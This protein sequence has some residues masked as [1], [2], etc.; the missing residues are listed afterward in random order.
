MP[1]KDREVSLTY[2][3]AYQKRRFHNDKKFRAR[4]LALVRKNDAR[5]RKEVVTLIKEFRKNG[6]LLCVEKESCCLTAHHVDPAQKEFEIGR[7]LGI[8]IGIDKVIVELAKCVCLCGNCHS[9]VHAG[10]LKLKST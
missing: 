5:R 9:K 3:R 6:C 7:A 4:H 2:R 8:K 1:F 10:I